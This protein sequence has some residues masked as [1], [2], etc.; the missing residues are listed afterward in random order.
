MTVVFISLVM[1]LLTVCRIALV[2]VLGFLCY[3]IKYFC[4]RI[5]FSVSDM[6]F[7]FLY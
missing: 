1:P 4:Q 2:F 3:H 5:F 7:D 6:H